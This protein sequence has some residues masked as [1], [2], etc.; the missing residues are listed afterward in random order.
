[1]SVLTILSILAVIL[2][3]AFLV[4]SLVEYFFGAI[5][6]NVPK[7]AP[8]KWLLMY[9]AAGVGVAGAFIYK[10]DLLYLLGGF[11]E[12]NIPSTWFGVLLT[13]LGIGRG[14]NF[15][16]DIVQKYFIKPAES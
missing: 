14:S 2:L 16:H 4:E 11:M 9:V 6:N 13:G 1:M 3:M 10:F 8:Y 12:V 7:L 5:V 15:I